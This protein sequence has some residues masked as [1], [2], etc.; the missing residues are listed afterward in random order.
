MAFRFRKSIRLAPGV[1]MN[2]SSRGVSTT[3]GPRGAS[4]NFSS[5][6][7]YLN[8][9]IPGTGLS[10]RQRIGGPS[11][12][13][14]AR[15]SE[16]SFTSVSVTVSVSDDG[17]V[18]FRDSDGNPLPDRVVNIAKKQKGDNIRLLIQKKCDEINAQTEA[19][20]K[21]HLDTPNPDIKPRYQPRGF[22]EPEPTP[23]NPKG[24]GLLGRLFESRR[25]KIEQFNA[26][27]RQ[28][29]ERE[30]AEWRIRQKEFN[31]A[32]KRR[33]DMI[34]HGIYNDVHAMETFLEGELH[35]ITWPRETLIST[36]VQADGKCVFAD[37]DLPEIEDMP[38]KTAA[39]PQRGY[40]LNI[41]DM[42]P[43]QIQKLYMN[44]VHGIGFRIVGE[45][46][47]ALPIA[48]IVVL[49]AFSQRNDPGTG[50]ITDQY[51][52]SVRVER[53]EWSKIRFGN[54]QNLDVVE[55][56]T[57]FDLRRNMTKNGIFKPI[58]PFS[59]TEVTP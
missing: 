25:L 31:E 16:P 24:L 7:T 4:V 17:T 19:L 2:F 55:A 35:E 3:I 46:F 30:L 34:E 48:E 28:E 54:L 21:L 51:L 39:V 14:R 11:P 9:G 45:I 42:S 38:S 20:G 37:V 18:S 1:R 26:K 13:T 53:K 40:K 15:R 56:L 10:S 52:Y 32:E 44:H 8:A 43:T 36:E 5:R 59:P 22:S 49:S 27:Q 12:K 50:H 47:A 41:K 57:K 33:K 29:F 6:G 58:T 23:P